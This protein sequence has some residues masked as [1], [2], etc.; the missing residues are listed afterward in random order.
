MCVVFIH[1][2]YPNE[3]KTKQWMGNL[4][5]IYHRCR[6]HQQSSWQ[7][8]LVTPVCRWRSHFPHIIIFVLRSPAVFLYPLCT[9]TWLFI[10]NSPSLKCK[11]LNLFLTLPPVCFLA[12][13]YSGPRLFHST[14]SNDFL[15]HAD[16]IPSAWDHTTKHIC[17][18]QSFPT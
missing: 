17:I 10:S 5:A 4:S 1:Q 9:S 8:C 18:H 13:I 15:L 7:S 3:A 14:N 12:L 2:L 11:L 16:C 6:L